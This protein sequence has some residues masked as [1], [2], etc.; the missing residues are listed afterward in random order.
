MNPTYFWKISFPTK[1]TGYVSLQQ[2]TA[3]YQ[4]V[5]YYKSTNNGQNCVRNEIPTSM[6]GTPVNFLAQGIGF[7]DK[8]EAG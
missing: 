2:N 6:F 4:S 8:T 5:V 3:T 7:V 1:K